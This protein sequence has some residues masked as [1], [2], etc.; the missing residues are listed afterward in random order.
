MVIGS[1]LYVALQL[2]SLVKLITRHSSF[3]AFHISLGLQDSNVR[4]VLLLMGPRLIGVAVVQFAACG[5]M[6]RQ[7][8]HVAS[9]LDH[10]VGTGQHQAGA[11][12][13]W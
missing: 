13:G 2:P 3:S 7:V 9:L 5:G 10:E 4:Q 11:Q 1:V 8:L 6:G 12:R